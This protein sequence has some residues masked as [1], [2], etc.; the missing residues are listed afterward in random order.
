MNY[1][2]GLSRFPLKDIHLPRNL[3][4]CRQIRPLTQIRFQ[5]MAPIR[6]VSP[7]SSF[8]SPGNYDD[9]AGSLRSEQDSDTDDDIVAMG[10]PREVAAHD[11][12]VLEEEDAR[13]KLLS[14]G[15][16]SGVFSILNR[17]TTG[18]LNREYSKVKIGKK[19]KRR[20]KRRERQRIKRSQLE[21]GEDE[22]GEL[23]YELEDGGLNSSRSSLSEAGS[24][25]AEEW[26]LQSVLSKTTR[27]PR[28]WKRWTLISSA[29]A[30]IVAIIALLALKKSM[31]IKKH[32]HGIATPLSNG[33]SIFKPTT[34]LISLDGFRADFLQ[35]GI[36]PTL[37][38]FIANG[39]S[40]KWMLPSFPSV[41]FPNHFTLVTGLYPESHGIVGNTFW[42]PVLEEQ[43]F[44]THVETSMTP[45]WWNGEPLWV[46]AE[47]Q[48]VR[49][50]IH[51]WP[52]SEAHIMNVE[53]AFLD[54][55]NR[56]ESL[57]K[58]SD[59]IMEWL[60]M[61]GEQEIK[62]GATGPERPQVIFSYVP[63]VDVM[64]HK[65]GPN[66]TEVWDTIREV[67]VFLGQLFNGLEERNLNDLVNIVIVSDHG[68]ATTDTSRMVQLDD[69]I[70]VDLVEHMDGWPLYGL[71]PKDMAN[72]RELYNTLAAE[73]KT[74][75]GFEVYL[76]DEN[77]PER[78]HFKDNPRIAPLWIVPTT[79][80]AIVTKKDF[81]VEKAKAEGTIY[82]PR[83]IHGYDHEH[84]LMRAIF[85][86]KGPAFPHT[87]NSQVEVFRKLRLANA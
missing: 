26:K 34:I 74:H 63:I 71:R 31:T 51:M 79:G 30:C 8:L 73:A 25:S 72:L 44:Y 80:W 50:A 4:L 54:K 48:G 2:H 19:E 84:P 57:S 81:D 87:P 38:G 55:F 13:E 33:T 12:S 7:H 40:P 65:F 39:V 67:D 86:A 6:E 18:N 46:T 85:V 29:I 10:N 3:L 76:R 24:D 59:R 64:G 77:M 45:R 69:I 22:E 66:S 21:H 61:P 75:P 15:Q 70:D 1:H 62:A 68:M 5:T 9:D 83:G 14:K 17:V 28:N 82:Q 42:D 11:K 49:S 52:G 47:N 32:K 53:P 20:E 78:Y 23:M 36:T 60:D 35:R 16:Q 37:N 43:F 56:S 58:K 27:T 41:T